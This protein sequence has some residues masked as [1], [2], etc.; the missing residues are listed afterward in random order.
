[1]NMTTSLDSIPMKTI[2]K[3]NDPLNDDSDDPM[4]KDILNEFQQELEINT[5]KPPANPKEKYNINY[6]QNNDNNQDNYKDN[7]LDNYK[8]NYQ[9]NCING[10]CNLRPLSSSKSNSLN[11][12]PYYNQEYIKKVGIIVVVVILI[13]SPLIMPT[14]M[15]KL[16]LSILTIVETY[17]FY[18][19]IIILFISLYIIY[20]YKVI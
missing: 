11:Q 18:F 14:I 9:D 2:N 15:E 5:H 12:N 16:P 8:D 1:M 19:K 20:Y 13:F 3:N 17:E 6:N 7:C 10:K 4:V